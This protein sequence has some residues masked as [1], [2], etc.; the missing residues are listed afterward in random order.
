[1]GVVD[2]LKYFG[3]I[4]SR[5]EHTRVVGVTDLDDEA[6]VILLQ[7]QGIGRKLL[8]FR[9][10]F[11]CFGGGTRLKSVASKDFGGTTLIK[12]IINNKILKLT[13]PILSFES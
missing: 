3:F 4:E 9:F 13:D 6:V 7:L 2:F 1:M 8:A 5:F 10:L 12:S 11:R